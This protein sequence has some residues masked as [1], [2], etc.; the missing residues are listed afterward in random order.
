MTHLMVDATVLPCVRALTRQPTSLLSPDSRMPRSLTV[1]AS[2]SFL[3]VA[4]RMSV[5]AIPR[6]WYQ[7]QPPAPPEMTRATT[8]ARITS[9]I[10]R[11]SRRVGGRREGLR[12][13]A[14]FGDA[15]VFPF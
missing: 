1:I 2:L 15:A 7:D 3:T 9:L 8:T 13:A 10:P 11:P 4:V 14:P 6:L 12:F 5:R